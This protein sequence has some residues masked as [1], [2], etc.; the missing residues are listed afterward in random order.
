MILLYVTCSG[1]NEHTDFSSLARLMSTY[2]FGEI[3]VRVSEKESPADGIRLQWIQDLVNYCKRGE[4]FINAALH[5]KRQWAED[6]CRGEVVPELKKLL[7]LRDI[8]NV[9]FFKRVRLDCESIRHGT[10]ENIIGN[11]SALQAKIR[12]RFVFCC[13][14]RNEQFLQ[15][16]LA[17]GVVFDCFYHAEHST[18]RLPEKWH[19]PV[20]ENVLHGYAGGINPINVYDALGSISLVVDRAKYQGCICIEAGKGLRGYDGNLSLDKCHRYLQKAKLWYEFYKW[21]GLSY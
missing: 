10:D 21:Q 4:I 20:F 1:A 19:T 14:E 18:G 7:D 11:L 13:N 17:K 5:I 8:Y 6:M 3:S 16:M 12:R 9:P 15:Q 2:Q